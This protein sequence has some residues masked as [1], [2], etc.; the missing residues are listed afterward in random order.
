MG[1]CPT[2]LESGEGFLPKSFGYSCTGTFLRE[3]RE[4]EKK[5]MKDFCIV[6]LRIPFLTSQARIRVLFLELSLSEPQYT[7]SFGSQAAWLPYFQSGEKYDKLT[8]GLVV[9]QIL[10]F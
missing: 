4:E 10:A 8:S 9:L 3:L 6:V 1:V 7:A 5:K 2:V